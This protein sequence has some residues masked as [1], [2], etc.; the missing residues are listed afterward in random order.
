MRNACSHPLPN[1]T[2]KAQLGLSTFG[3]SRRLDVAEHQMYPS[4]GLV[5]PGNILVTANEEMT[6]PVPKR[7]KTGDGTH[8]S[9]PT[10]WPCDLP[11]PD[12]HIL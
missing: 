12:R 3:I 8:R 5:E 10:T 4:S 9:D 6:F 1:G 11:V 7:A 2:S